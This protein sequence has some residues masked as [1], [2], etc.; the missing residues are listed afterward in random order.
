[1][2]DEEKEHSELVWPQAHGVKGSRSLYYKILHLFQH[3]IGYFKNFKCFLM[4]KINGASG[5]SLVDKFY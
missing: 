3:N 4:G 5:A 1:M 2:T